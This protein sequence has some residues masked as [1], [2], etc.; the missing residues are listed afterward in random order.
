M[1]SHNHH[2][3]PQFC[4]KHYLEANKHKLSAEERDQVGV[5]MNSPANLI[6]LTERDHIKAHALLYE[7]YGDKR[8]AG[9]VQ[10]L[11]GSFTEAKKLWKQAGAYGDSHR[12]EAT[13]ALLKSEGRHFWDPQFQKQQAQKRIQKE[14]ALLTRSEG[15]KKGG[16][17]RNLNV[18]IKKEDKYLFLYNEEPYLCIFNCET[19]GDALKQLHSAIPTK[20]Q[21]VT[22]LLKGDRGTLNGWS[23]KKL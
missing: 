21:R 15:G 8:D 7:I 13:H 1:P 14:D 18:A 16:R 5:Y 2:I 19:G 11:M 17:N 20:L 22:P 12:K 6:P 4:F 3:I 9:A 23:C 10:L